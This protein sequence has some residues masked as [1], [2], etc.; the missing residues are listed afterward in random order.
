MHVSLCFDVNEGDDPFYEHARWYPMCDYLR[1]LKGNEF[2][3]QV[4]GTIIIQVHTI[5]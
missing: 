2:I 1:R 5:V 3:E 4:S